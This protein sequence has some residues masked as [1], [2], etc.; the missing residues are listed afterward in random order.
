[1]MDN[2][3]L[4][5]FQKIK[6]GTIIA[7]K[8][9]LLIYERIINDLE[10]KRY[11]FD[12]KKANTAIDWIE[13]HC[14]HVEGVLAPGNLKL[15]LWQKAFIS[16]L[17]GLVDE[18][19]QRVYGEVL[20][21]IGR[22]N[23][24]SA[25]AS[26][27]AN[28]IW[29]AEGGYG[30]KIFCLA[31]KLEQADIV[32]NTIWQM[33]QLDPEYQDM[34]EILSE[35][36]MHNKK[37]NDD[38]ML[39]RH[40]RTDL[41]IP[42]TNSTIKKIASAVKRSDGFN[43][44][45]CLADEI[46]AWDG[47]KGLKQYEVMRSGMGARGKDGLMLAM[48]TSGYVNDSIFDE[49]MKRST[50]FLLGDSKETRLLPMLYMIDN[51][52]KWNDINELR[53][54]NPN[55]GVS[56]PV[57]Y[58]LEEISIAEGSLS[59]KTEFLTKYCCIKQNSSLAWLSA[60]DVEK[61]CGEH[62]NIEDFR[63]HYAVCGVD[64][65]QVRDLTACLAVIEK[66]NHFY[67]FAQ[68]FLPK[69]KIDLA[70]QR[71]GIPYDAFIKRGLLTPSGEEFVD[72]NDCY[73]WF[74]NLIDEKEIY[75]L[76]TGYDRYSAQYLVQQCQ[77]RGMHMDDVYQGDNLWGI[78]QTVQALIEERRIHIG[79]NDLLK[80]HLLDSAIKMS[81]ERGRGR[82][83]KVR[84]SAHIDGVAALLDAFTVREK[85]YDEIGERLRNDS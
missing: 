75:P 70:S 79:D 18:D 24:K 68:F 57:S 56:I 43:P 64:L 81:T 3:I 41:T 67:V 84:P 42:G 2:Y 17:F 26:A 10:Q 8:W 20:L 49:L 63:Q 38:S 50:R 37:V 13:S 52:D 27:I 54:A 31:P 15:E 22:K 19:G 14:F 73:N 83:V 48:T 82:L 47:D 39:P 74:C 65:S 80:I 60:Q 55:L 66:K 21:L 71:D 61:M 12:Q 35:K 76:K 30:T 7:G 6:D 58:M 46:A 11:I 77:H 34:K 25:L 16:C 28:Y 32:Y 33:V 29:R 51:P 85:Y 36:D 69:E 23:G 53:K 62:L 1:M 72:Y 5:Y 9:I 44:S 40:R 4:S 59:K 45:C 78:I